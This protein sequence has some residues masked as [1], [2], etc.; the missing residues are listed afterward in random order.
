M[1]TKQS[2]LSGI[3]QGYIQSKLALIKVL[4]EFEIH[5]AERT[6]VPMKI[7]SSSLVYAAEGGVWIKLKKLNNNERISDQ[8]RPNKYMCP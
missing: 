7:K 2:L 8:N 6:P 1:P 3:R 5:L 4:H